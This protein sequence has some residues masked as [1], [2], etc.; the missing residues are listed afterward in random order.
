MQKSSAT[1]LERSG[2]SEC[3]HGT[4]IEGGSDI[5]EDDIYKD[6]K[7]TIDYPCGCKARVLVYKGTQ[8]KASMKCPGC[9]KYAIFCY[10]DMTAIRSNAVKRPKF[11]FTNKYSYYRD[12]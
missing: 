10:D 7:G 2:E 11:G 5:M 6:L 3:M 12:N 1:S 4:E 8:G 9:G